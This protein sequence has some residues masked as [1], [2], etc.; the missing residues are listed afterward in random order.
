MGQCAC[1]PSS[2]PGNHRKRSIPVFHDFSLLG[3]EAN[4]AGSEGVRQALQ[5]NRVTSVE[6]DGWTLRA[7]QRKGKRPLVQQPSALLGF[8]GANHT[9]LAVVTWLNVDFSATHPP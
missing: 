6:M 3:I 1:L 5:G 2:R 7:C 8:E 4:G 9:V